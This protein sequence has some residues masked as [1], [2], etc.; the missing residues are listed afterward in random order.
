MENHQ[1]AYY[2]PYFQ[3]RNG[4]LHCEDRNS[5]EITEWLRNKDVYLY[6]PVYIYSKNKIVRNVEGY[7]E[8]LT[9]TKMDFQLN[10]SVK[11]NMN[12]HILS[13][14]K[15]LG[16]S[17][18]LVS[19]MELQ[20]ALRLGFQPNSIVLNGNGKQLWEIELA[21]H[22]GCILNIDSEFNL[23]HTLEACSRLGK[24]A[25]V[26]LRVNPDIDPAILCYDECDANS[27]SDTFQKR[28]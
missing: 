25:R 7:K 16:C 4:L 23:T 13:I 19:G 9:K 26:F 20:L 14:M 2:S 27:Q 21:I 10:Y 12:P 17:V 18:T 28:K 22:H 6:S 1:N 15:D 3:Y 24:D 5:R 11:A 8:P